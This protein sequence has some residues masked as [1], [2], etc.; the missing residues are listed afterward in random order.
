LEERKKARGKNLPLLTHV[1]QVCN[2]R[3]LCSLLRHLCAYR[4]IPRQHDEYGDVRRTRTMLDGLGFDLTGQRWLATSRRASKQGCRR[5]DKTFSFVPTPC[6]TVTAST[7][8]EPSRED[9][10]CMGEVL[11][12][13][14][15]YYIRSMG[16]GARNPICNP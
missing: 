6:R 5:L 3:R 4:S 12:D 1:C 8:L 9:R 14:I 16:L 10:V 11:L 7:R 2:G 15:R 13:A